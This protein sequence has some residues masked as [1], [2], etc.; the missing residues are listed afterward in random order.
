MPALANTSVI[1]IVKNSCEPSIYVLELYAL[2]YYYIINYINNLKSSY[3]H[4]SCEISRE[5]SGKD[6]GIN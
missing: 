6:A 5:K 4:Y 3:W 2:L 1:V